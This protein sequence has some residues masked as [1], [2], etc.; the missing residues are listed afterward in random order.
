MK[1]RQFLQNSAALGLGAWLS[2]GVLSSL[3]PS[4]SFA[5]TLSGKFLVILRMRGGWDVTLGPDAWTLPEGADEKD[6]FLE[7]RPDDILRSGQLALGPA[8]AGLQPWMDQISVVNGMLMSYSNLDH[9]ANLNYAVCGDSS[10]KS[11][12]FSVELSK[13]KAPLLGILSSGGLRTLDRKVAVTRVSS[14]SSLGSG[15]VGEDVS[16]GGG[17][18]NSP[19]DSGLRE[20]RLN[21][22]QILGLVAKIQALPKDLSPAV[23]EATQTALAFESGLSNILDRNVSEV[24]LGDLDTHQ[25]HEGT[26]LQ[27]LRGR[28]DAVAAF[29]KVFASRPYGTTGESLLDRTVFYVTSDFARTPSISSAGGKDHNPMTNSAILFGHGI[30][31]G[32]AWGRSRLM[33]RNS[34]GRGIPLHVAA[35]LN[36]DGVAAKTK[37]EA[38]S[39]N[40]EFIRPGHVLST[41]LQALD[42]PLSTVPVLADGKMPAISALLKKT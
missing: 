33:N 12:D 39:G 22:P 11:A 16:I 34:S 37:D 24:G 26:H 41:V 18:P 10:L 20:V 40:F 35:M 2:G 6:L 19:I 7:Y 31:G 27:A 42:L 15:V 32:R 28:F 29:L 23:L 21:S 38:M 4:N 17:R 9:V 3:I 30:Q 13:E 14:L 5:Q 1:R 36:K 8:M 25:N